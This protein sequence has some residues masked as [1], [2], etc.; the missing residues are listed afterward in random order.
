MGEYRDSIAIIGGLVPRYLIP[1]GQ[2]PH[3]G[4]TDIDLA[5][6]F[7]EIS[8]ESYQTLLGIL[9][10]HG[11]KQDKDQPFKFYKDLP[12]DITV[13]LDLMAGEYGGTGRGHRTQRI[14][15]V[16]ARKTRGCDLVFQDTVAITIEGEMP[17]GSSNSVEIK[18]SNIIPFLAMKGFALNDR[19]KE[20]D[21]YDIYYCLKNYPGGIAAIRE[22]L[23]PHKN[24]KLVRKGL[25]NI[26]S[27]F[28]TINHIGPRWVTDFLNITDPEERELVQR[29]AFELVM[30]LIKE[31]GISRGRS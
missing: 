28:K 27:K 20:K 4:S 9:K 18:I 17:D 13:E 15:D 23:L 30:Q 16:N 5:I 8:N 31:A 3:C 26:Y 14:Q 19:K 29:D 21:A 7:K 11:Y 25:E 1:E 10:S 6:N 12:E 2:D 24:N 22:C